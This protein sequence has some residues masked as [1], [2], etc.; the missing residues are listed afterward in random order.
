LLRRK[1]ERKFD[2]KLLFLIVPR[3]SFWVEAGLRDGKASGSEE[4]K[5]VGSELFELYS[6]GK[7]LS[8]ALVEIQWGF[9]MYIETARE[10]GMCNMEIGHKHSIL[11][12]GKSDYRRGLDW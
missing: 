8:R 3:H 1:I 5:A 2:R 4:G 7:K 11:S 10:T 12:R 9:G 6:R